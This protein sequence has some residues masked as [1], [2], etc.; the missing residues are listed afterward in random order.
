[1]LLRTNKRAQRGALPV[2]IYVA[3][4]LIVLL[5]WDIKA[6]FCVKFI[7]LEK[8]AICFLKI[9]IFKT[10]FSSSR[11]Q[12]ELLFI[13]AIVALGEDLQHQVRACICN[14]ELSESLPLSKTVA[15][16]DIINSFIN[17]DML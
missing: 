8:S 13:V 17:S 14:S 7:H 3:D 10:S 9:M 5:Y 1:M 11:Y 15:S 2:I 16:F 12:G 6:V 4:E